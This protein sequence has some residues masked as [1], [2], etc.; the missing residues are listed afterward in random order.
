MR[1]SPSRLFRHSHGT[2]RREQTSAPSTHSGQQTRRGGYV[3]RSGQFGGGQKPHNDRPWAGVSSPTSAL[4][5]NIKGEAKSAIDKVFGEY[6]VPTRFPQA[7]LDEVKAIQASPGIDDPSLVDMTDKAFITIDNDDSKDLDQAIHMERNGTGYDVYYALTDASYYVKPGSALFREALK[8]GTSLYFPTGSVPMLPPELSED[9]VSLNPNVDRRA[10]VFKISLDAEGTP[11]HTEVTRARVHSR[12]QLTY[13]GVQSYYDDPS[14]S[15]LANQEWT[16]SLDLLREVGEL[17]MKQAQKRGV[18]QYDRHSADTALSADQSHLIPTEEAR[19]MVDDWNA[20]I[21]LLTNSEGAKLLMERLGKDHVHGIFK[22]HP[23]PPQERLEAFRDQISNLVST[24]GLPETF[25]WQPNQTLADYVAALPKDG[26]LHR[27]SV[28]IESMAIRTNSPAAFA[29]E[30]GLHYGIQTKAYS[31]F[32]APM[33]EIVG[34]LTHELFLN[35][36]KNASDSLVEEAIA[37]GN[38][39][40][41][42]QKHLER[43]LVKAAVAEMFEAEFAKPANQRTT[44]TGTITG[45]T[46]SKVFLQLDNPP[47]QVA[48]QL[49]DLPQRYSLADS[50]VSLKDPQGNVGFQLGQPLTVQ[51]KSFDAQNGQPTLVPV[52]AEA[53]DMRKAS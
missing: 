26:P 49:R 45:V 19:H 50:G 38:A 35:G 40:E 23:A 22:Q 25:R 1:T 18:V 29:D 3:D 46:P 17:R 8:R 39:G 10:V 5:W 12:S 16:G 24:A 2:T 15:K 11:L 14:H 47:S 31:R 9:V 44:W 43:D 32:S 7:V 37:S 33:R 28:A 27:Y 42:R 52:A 34:I 4:G 30:P 48:V 53:S 20:E 41:T 21:S 13:S 36:S 6:Q 51:L